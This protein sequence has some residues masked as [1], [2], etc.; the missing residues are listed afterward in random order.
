[1]LSR[2]LR[3]ESKPARPQ[4]SVPGRDHDPAMDDHEL[5][6]A[7]SR[8]AV[9]DW[10]AARD[11]VAAAG[12]DWEL[13]SRR[14][15]LLSDAA[16]ANDRWLIDWLRAAPA[17]PAAVMLH[18]AMLLERA[19][20]ARGSAPANQTSQA[21]FQAYA[22]LSAAAGQV[23]QRAI[24][25]AGPDDPTP[26]I[27]LL[28]AMFGAGQV[29]SEQ[30]R[31]VLAEARR[32]APHHFELHLTLVNLLCEKWFGSHEQMFAAAREAAAAAPPGSNTV[33]VPFVAHFEYAMREFSWDKATGQSVADTANYL[34][35]REVQMEL[36]AWA[37][38]WRAGTPAPGR[39]MTCRNWLALYYMM[40]NRRAEAREVFAE[41]G[42]YAGGTVAWAFFLGNVDNG[43]VQGYKLA[44]SPE[45][46]P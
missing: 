33:M 24:A 22:E 37:Q 14:I 41:I 40:S 17:D 3:R 43:F 45:W 36:D 5:R 6:A 4:V 35:T 18:A 29:H 9:G 15:M 26:F 44:H 42:P 2:F 27:L 32:R 20:E 46:T 10:G 23:S 11:V 8:V 38:K 19:G 21:Q 13:R 39:G 12:A 34:Q 31:Q 28:D 1:M 30:F 16:A 7:R 25:L